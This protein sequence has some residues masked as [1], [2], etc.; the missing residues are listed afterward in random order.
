[1]AQLIGGIDRR[2]ELCIRTEQVSIS[3]TCVFA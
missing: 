2:T 3:F 1:M